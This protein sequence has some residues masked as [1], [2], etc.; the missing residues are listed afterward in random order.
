MGGQSCLKS[1]LSATQNTEKK[2][3]EKKKE[4]EKEWVKS[5][6]RLKKMREKLRR[7]VKLKTWLKTKLGRWG[8]VTWYN[9][10]QSLH[11]PHFLFP[12]A[13]IVLKS[14]CQSIQPDTIVQV[15][16]PHIA[17]TLPTPDTIVHTWHE[18]RSKILFHFFVSFWIFSFWFNQILTI[19]LDIPIV[20]SDCTFWLFLLFFPFFF[21]LMVSGCL[22]VSFCFD[23]SFASL[24]CF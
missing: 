7:I 11:L 3:K 20:P 23:F 17:H 10:N 21:F 1:R 13:I 6:R 19:C 16:C 14:V 9:S 22:F 8:S 24:S 18:L 15:Y 5:M 12:F 2:R 4:Q